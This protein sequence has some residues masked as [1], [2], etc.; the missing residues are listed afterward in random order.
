MKKTLILLASCAFGASAFASC[1]TV[2]DAKGKILSESPNPPVDMAYQ[3]HQT[4]P[5]RYGPGASMSFGIADGNCGSQVDQWYDGAPKNVA[6]QAHV[7]PPA[8]QA[9]RH[10]HHHRDTSQKAHRHAR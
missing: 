10:H 2:M 6:W 4:V 5:Y 7:P 9:R 3:L 8:R 1:Y